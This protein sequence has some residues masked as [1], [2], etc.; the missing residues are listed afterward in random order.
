MQLC[1]ALDVHKLMFYEYLCSFV[2][3]LLP[4]CQFTAI[5]SLTI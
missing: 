1:F 5:K 3:Y 2:I 4:L